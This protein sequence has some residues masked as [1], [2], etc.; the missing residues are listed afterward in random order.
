MDW[1]Y[2][3]PQTMLNLIPKNLFSFDQYFIYGNYSESVAHS[4]HANVTANLKLESKNQYLGPLRY[5]PK[6]EDFNKIQSETRARKRK[7][8]VPKIG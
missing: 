8:S 3:L 5:A 2:L 4:I 6:R 1:D 7:Q